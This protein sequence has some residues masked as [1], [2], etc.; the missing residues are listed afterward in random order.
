MP[1][2]KRKKQSKEKRVSINYGNFDP[3]MPVNDFFEHLNLDDPAD[4]EEALNNFISELEYGYFLMWEAVVCVE[5]G[6]NL[7]KKQ[8]SVLDELLYFND[9]DD[10]Q[11]LYIDEIPR[12]KEA[13]YEIARKIVPRLLVEL[14]KTDAV[15]YSVMHEGWANLVE[16][17]EEH[18]QDLSLP[19]GIESTLDIFPHDL[20]HRLWL[21]TCFDA[22]SG[23]GQ[24]EALTLEDEDQKE[25]V[26]WFIDLLREHKDSVQYFDLT[27]ETMLTRVIIPSKDENL[28]TAMIMEQLGLPTS[29]VRIAECL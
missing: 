21:Q 11:I 29:Q 7:S 17:L 4:L 15:M 13:W 5:Q 28:F 19:E 20:Q 25:R 8:K 16:A 27:L 14:F 12:P 6:V 2:R 1:K 3:D 26:E 10:D 22:L 24:S 23:L 18:A 9:N